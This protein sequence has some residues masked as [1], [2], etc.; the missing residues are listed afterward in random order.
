MKYTTLFLYVSLA[1]TVAMG[2]FHTSTH[3]M[4]QQAVE[5]NIIIAKTGYQIS[6]TTS[7]KIFG[8]DGNE[9]FN[10]VYS[11][12]AS[13]SAGICF[14]LHTLKPWLS[15]SDFAPYQNQ[16]TPLRFGATIRNAI[17]DTTYGDTLNLV[18]LGKENINDSVILLTKLRCKNELQVCKTTDILDG[19]LVWVYT[20]DSA[21]VI[22]P[23][24][25]SIASYNTDLK[26]KTKVSPPAFALLSSDANDGRR[27]IGGIYLAAHITNANISFS[28]AGILVP[29]GKS[30]TI[31]TP[32]SKKGK[33]PA[34]NSSSELTPVEAPSKKDDKKAASKKNKKR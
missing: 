17:N 27:L 15:D 25:F 19:W 14:P 23:T 11:V 22:T 5:N 16:Y 18:E 26:K 4:V 33:S 3:Q 13:T 8:R 12:G 21:D 9:V 32:F 10:Y 28:L 29:D 1:P 2:Q 20:A 30:W 31:A 24:S 34:L 7:G 6:D